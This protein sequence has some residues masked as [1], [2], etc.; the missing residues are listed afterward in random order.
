[1][2]KLTTSQHDARALEA[3]QG[4]LVGSHTRD[5]GT[6]G[7]V[8]LIGVGGARVVPECCISCCCCKGISHACSKDTAL[9]SCSGLF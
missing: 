9:N 1:M 2:Q 8:K 4:T 7:E 3:G 5:E 6:R